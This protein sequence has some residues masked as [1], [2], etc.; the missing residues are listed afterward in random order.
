M[1]WVKQL[2]HLNIAIARALQGRK[3]WFVD[4]DAQRTA[5]Q[6]FKMREVEPAIACSSYSDGV[7]LRSQVKLQAGNYD[8]VIIDA[9]GRDS[10]AL[11]A[12]LSLSDVLLIPFA[13]RSYDVWAL[14]DISQLVQDIQATRDDLRVLTILNQADA[15]GADNAGA[16]IIIEDYPHFEHLTCT[17]GRRKSFAV[18]AGSGQS[19]LEAGAKD[20]K[21]IK[22][23][24]D[25]VEVLFI[26]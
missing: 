7:I 1:E 19:V 4:G 13:P 12:A 20:D 16:S 11:R 17:I 8:D 9:G 15:R 23:I 26:D 6:S 14:N 22:E 18:C 24:N 25:L 21:A 2:W 5:E 3:V 10:S